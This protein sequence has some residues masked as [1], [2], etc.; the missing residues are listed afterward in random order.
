MDSFSYKKN[1]LFKSDYCPIYYLLELEYYHMFSYRVGL[2][3]DLQTMHGGKYLKCVPAISK[4][5]LVTLFKGFELWFRCFYSTGLKMYFK[6]V[7]IPGIYIHITITAAIA[8][9]RL[10]SQCH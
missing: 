2:G 7:E 1:S 8:I 9:T 4:G 3:A 10:F 6:V 5:R